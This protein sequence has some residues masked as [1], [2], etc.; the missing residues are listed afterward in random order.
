[1]REF[2]AE[3]RKEKEMEASLQFFVTDSLKILAALGS[4]KQ[5]ICL[6]LESAPVINIS[7]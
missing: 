6:G 5:F 2:G 4:R 1:M 3:R 7:S